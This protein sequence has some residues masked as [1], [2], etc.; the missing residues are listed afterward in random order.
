[1]PKKKSKLSSKKGK[2]NYAPKISETKRKES[3]SERDIF[4]DHGPAII[5]SRLDKPKV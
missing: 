4:D 5:G 2:K 3:L 1:M